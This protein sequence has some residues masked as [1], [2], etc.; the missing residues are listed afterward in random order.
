MFLAANSEYQPK[1][2]RELNTNT[3]KETWRLTVLYLLTVLRDTG[4]RKSRRVDNNLGS[5][6][7]EQPFYVFSTPVFSSRIEN[8]SVFYCW[9]FAA[10]DHSASWRLLVNEQF[11]FYS[12]DNICRKTI[13]A[14]MFSYAS[15]YYFL[16]ICRKSFEAWLCSTC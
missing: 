9:L 2:C 3:I 11:C 10:P 13:Q 16:F 6:E 8:A 4:I 12:Q 7:T 14:D 5:L 15:K 1:K